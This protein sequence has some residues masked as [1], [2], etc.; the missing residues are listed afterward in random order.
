MCSNISAYCILGTISLE[1]TGKTSSLEQ[2]I[3]FVR[4]W[5]DVIFCESLIET[6]YISANLTSNIYLS[7]ILLG[8]VFLPS[9]LE[10]QNSYVSNL[11]GK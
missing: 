11:W 7:S 5:E 2:K 1:I 3:K 9:L 4:F 6:T 10:V 8:T